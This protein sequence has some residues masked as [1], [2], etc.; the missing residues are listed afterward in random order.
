MAAKQAPLPV[1]LKHV[2]Q[3]LNRVTID[4]LTLMRA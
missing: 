4:M 1:F 2:S 3:C